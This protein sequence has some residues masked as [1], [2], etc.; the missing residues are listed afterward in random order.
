MASLA[1]DDLDE[2]YGD[3]GCEEGRLAQRRARERAG[4]GRSFAGRGPR[5]YRRSDER[6]RE[7]VCDRLMA[8]PAIDPGGVT[9]AVADGEVTL[10]GHVPA[11]EMKRGAEACAA[12]ILGVRQVHDRLRVAVDAR[13]PL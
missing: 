4:A 2:R 5:G 7:D 8:D 13:Q 11:P 9:V 12:S 1:D 3:L 6:I 10:E